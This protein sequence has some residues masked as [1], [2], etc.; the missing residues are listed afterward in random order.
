MP[1]ATVAQLA[2]QLDCQQASRLGHGLHTHAHAHGTDRQDNLG[3]GAIS[4]GGAPPLGGSYTA[5]SCGT[6]T[7]RGRHRE[8]QIWSSRTDAASLTGRPSGRS[9][10]WGRVSHRRFAGN[11]ASIVA[12]ADVCAK[13]V[14]IERDGCRPRKSFPLAIVSAASVFT[15]VGFAAPAIAV[16]TTVLW[17][18]C[19]SLWVLCVLDPCGHLVQL[20][21]TT[22]TCVCG[23]V[24]WVSCERVHKGLHSNPCEH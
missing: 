1:A 14:S 11:G 20:D 17:H 8:G 15:I 2:S 16:S 24:G 10:V 7:D 6:H 4:R 13:G 18:V 5:Q 22:G 9:E 23:C 21:S 12:A 19:A 3:A